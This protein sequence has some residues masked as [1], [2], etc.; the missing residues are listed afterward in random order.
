VPQ[1]Q[2]EEALRARMDR[3]HGESLPVAH[4][5]A[6]EPGARSLRRHIEQEGAHPHVCIK[7]C[8]AAALALAIALMSTRGIEVTMVAANAFHQASPSA[9]PDEKAAQL[10]RL[11]ERLF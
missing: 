2:V 9:S 10:A 7:S 8:G 5:P 4:F 1:E 6:G 3:A 11:A